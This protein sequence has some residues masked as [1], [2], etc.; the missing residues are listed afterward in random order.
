MCLVLKAAEKVSCNNARYK[1][2]CTT[3][4]IP[5]VTAH[6]LQW[7]PELTPG[8]M[9]LNCLSVGIHG[10]CRVCQ[11]VGVSMQVNFNPLTYIDH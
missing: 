3:A 4:G 2:Q 7:P 5:L 9:E 1:Y 11:F 6:S 10:N 8:K